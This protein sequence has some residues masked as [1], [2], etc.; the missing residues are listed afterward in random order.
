M[1]RIGTRLP[2]R[3][4]TEASE[5]WGRAP[6]RDTAVAHQA[7]GRPPRTSAAAPARARSGRTA[8]PRRSGRRA[9]PRDVVD[10]G[11]PE[12]AAGAS[13]RSGE[14]GQPP[15]VGAP[16]RQEEHPCRPG[17]AHRA[18]PPP[19]PGPRGA[20]RPGEQRLGPPAAA[21]GSA[22]STPSAATGARRTRLPDVEQHPG[23]ALLQLNQLRPVSRCVKPSAASARRHVPSIVVA[24]R[25]RRSR[26]WPWAGAADR[27]PLPGRLVQPLE[28]RLLQRQQR[29]QRVDRG[30]ARVGLPEHVVEHLERERPGVAG[31]QHVIQERR[32][33]QGALARGTADG[34]GS[35]A[36]RPCPSA[37]RRP[38]AGRTASPGMSRPLPGRSRGTGC[39]SC[40]G[41]GPSAGGPRGARSPRT[42]RRC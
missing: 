4:S 40:P 7:E 29:P 20:P 2:A 31:G 23:G 6:G 14:V 16:R 36:A 15:Q 38:A 13:D 17:A 11:D 42:A 26:R 1:L 28:G 10:P 25:R 41:T 24:A 22:V 5:R 9:G 3:R 19:R 32:Q 30:P 39:G 34:G 37:G 8:L 12:R 35:T 21:V 27:D 33:V 18:T